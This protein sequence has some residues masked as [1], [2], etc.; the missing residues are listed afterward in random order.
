[1]GLQLP[2][3]VHQLLVAF[4]HDL[5]ERGMLGIGALLADR[6][7]GADAGDHVLALGVDQELAVEELL[8]GGRIA[9]EGH[10]GGAVV[11]HV[12]EDHRLD[13]DRRA[14][15]GRDAVEAAVGD[16]PRIHPRAED[17]ADRSP[18]LFFGVLG[19]VLAEGLLDLVLEQADQLLHVLGAQLGVERHAALVLHVLENVLEDGRFH[20]EHDIA[21]HLDEAP[22][23]IVGEARIVALLDDALDGGVVEPQVENGV[24]HSGHR[25]ARPRAHRHQQRIVR[26]AERLAHQLLDAAQVLLHLLLELGRILPVVLVE[27]CA[28]LGRNGKPGGHRQTDRRHLSQVGALA[29]QQLL[30]VATPLGG[31]VAEEVHEFVS[32]TLFPPQ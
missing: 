7:R 22:V 27:L 5:F 2:L 20:A 26:I 15:L 31:T 24:H 12:A 30:H 16:G 29:T 18:Q 19:K 8:A 3:D 17:G 21:V 9:G 1:M 4:G 28:D 23:G 13:V 6:L 25:G 11:A 14:P 32:H 10:A